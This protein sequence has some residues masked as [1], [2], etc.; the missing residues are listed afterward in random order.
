M[1]AHMTPKLRLRQLSDSKSALNGGEVLRKVS[2]VY[3]MVGRLAFETDLRRCGFR[4]V[5]NGTMY[6]V[7]CNHE[8]L[9]LI[10]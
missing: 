1:P 7:F 8:Y 9:R 6:V 2:E 3:R 4:T 5:Q 10:V